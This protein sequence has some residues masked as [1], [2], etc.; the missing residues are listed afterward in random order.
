M[1]R[2]CIL[3]SII[4]GLILILLIFTACIIQVEMEG[5][6]VAPDSLKMTMTANFAGEESPVIEL[7][8]IGDTVYVKDPESQ[9]WMMEDEVESYQELAGT[10]DF[11][12]S[13]TEFIDVFEG[14]SLLSDEEIDGV[15]CYHIKGIVDATKLEDFS[16]DVAPMDM[17]DAE[18]WI[19]KKD[20]LVRQ[21]IF[22]VQADTSDSD[23]EIPVTGG[24]FSFTFKFSKYNEPIA[25]EAPKTN[26][27]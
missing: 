26:S 27:D 5:D 6:Y 15:L 17:L 8:K 20:Y 1:K 18:L 10:E 4:L 7:V 22:E 13:A 11:A 25:I 14:S 12:S 16:T 23:T 2:L 24:S 9:Q 19:G 3:V 21:M